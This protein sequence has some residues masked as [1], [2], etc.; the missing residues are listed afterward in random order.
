MESFI[1]D[2]LYEAKRGI[3]MPRDPFD[4]FRKIEELF[5]QVMEEDGMISGRTGHSISVQRIGN[6]TKVE[7]RGDVSEEDIEKL[8]R[9]YPD[10]DISVNEESVERSKPVEVIDDDESVEEKEEEDDDMEPEE[11][12]LKRFG[13]KKKEK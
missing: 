11:L 3:K 2:G 7:V 1:F 6:E 5:K 4:E 8:R 13:E 12:A 10:A 9:K